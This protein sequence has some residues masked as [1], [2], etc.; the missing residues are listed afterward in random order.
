MSL[1]GEM[2]ADPRYT[3]VLAGLGIRELSM[4]PSAIS[5][6][7]A[8]I[9]TS[10]SAEMTKLANRVL[11][12]R[13]AA[14]AEAIVYETMHARFPEHLEHGAGALVASETDGGDDE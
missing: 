12:A 1:C 11:A 6:I 13:S 14:E 2:A 4:N 7:K 5:V 9:R 10:T 3:W 8:I